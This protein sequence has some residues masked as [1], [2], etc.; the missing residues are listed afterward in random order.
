[1]AFRM[2]QSRS[3]QNLQGRLALIVTFA[4][5]ALLGADALSLA[6]SREQTLRDAEQ[7]TANLSRSLADQA[8]RIFQLMDSDLLGV[9]AAIEAAPF[10]HPTAQTEAWI[11]RIMAARAAARPATYALMVLDASGHVLVGSRGD[12]V[13]G[14]D[15]STSGLFAHHR[16][17]PSRAA[18]IGR[19]LRDPLDG[20][21]VLT[22][23]RRINAA[24]GGFAGVAVEEVP[25]DFFRKL[26]ASFDTG[27]DGVILLAR[28]DA[29]LLARWPGRATDIGA[30]LSASPLFKTYVGPGDR[31]NFEFMSLLDGTDRLASYTWV[32]DTPVLVMVGR[33]KQAVLENWR[34][35]L[36]GHVLGLAVV[37]GM[38]LLLARQLAQ[39]IAEEAAAQEQLITTNVQLARSEASTARAVQWLKLAEQIAHVG[40]WYLDVADGNTLT[41]SDEVYR[42]FGL[43]QEMFTPSLDLAL[44]FYLPEDSQAKAAALARC[45]QTCQPYEEFTR[46]VRPDGTIRHIFTRGEPQQDHAGRAV[47][48]FGVVMDM[49][50]QKQAEADLRH[51]TARAEA[52]NKALEAANAALETLAMQD[53]LTTLPNRRQFDRAL[54]Q[55]F[56]RAVRGHS[57]LALIMIDVDQFKQFNDLYGHQA[58]AAC[59]RAIAQT[60]PPLLNR[61][62]DIA[63]RYGGEELAVLLPGNTACG[64]RE[65]A[66]RIAASVRD[67]GMV[68]AGSP[69]G[70]VT[71]SAGVEVFAPMREA[72]RPADLVARADA[73]LYAAKRS[74]RNRVLCHSE[75]GL[76]APRA[77]E[78]SSADD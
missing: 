37:L 28:S 50:V 62:G 14:L 18:F 70:V 64:A 59:L 1:M 31:Q 32:D 22:V 77:A 9:R 39:K 19:P 7:E 75:L 23:S 11:Q 40:H 27:Q 58:G 73:A 17:D 38:L 44:A 3:R 2:R 45:L 8:H 61:P 4:I 33:A 68:H 34:L 13:R 76:A 43:D 71:I 54:D 67:L 49:T 24:D 6:G 51:A 41:W 65:L 60:L 12:Q 78:L 69:Y 30:D 5:F 74:G 72:D 52:A 55:E 16:D 15:F 66:H 47:A 36:W 42:I 63:A 46:L 25:A 21:W 35:T 48:V 29:V 56:R 26:Y 20:S 10:P 57:S 53:S